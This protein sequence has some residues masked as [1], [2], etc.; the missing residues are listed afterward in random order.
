MANWL[1]LEEMRNWSGII[2]LGFQYDDIPDDDIDRAL[3]D[4]ALFS[5]NT[6]LDWEDDKVLRESQRIPDRLKHAY[7]VAA[8][9]KSIETRKLEKAIELDTF[10]TVRCRSCIPNG[11]HRIRALQYLGFDSAPFSLSGH[12]DSLEELVRIAGVKC[13]EN[14]GRFVKSELHELTVDDITL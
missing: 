11:H 6:D 7:R 1:N 4:D 12:L 2:F 9:V 8:L 13:P 3:A 5:I 14:A 10:C